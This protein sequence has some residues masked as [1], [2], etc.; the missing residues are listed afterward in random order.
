MK[1]KYYL[2]KAFTPFIR[3][4]KDLAEGEFVE[5]TIIKRFDTQKEG[6]EFWRKY[7]A[8]NKDMWGLT[9]YEGFYLCENK[10]NI[11]YKVV[12]TLRKYKSKYKPA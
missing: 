9:G 8:E 12:K 5:Q 1:N 10:N 11:Y 7:K 2:I 4:G 6:I 3:M